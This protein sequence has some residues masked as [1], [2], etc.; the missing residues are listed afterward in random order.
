MSPEQ[1]LGQVEAGRRIVIADMEAGVGNLTRM[2]EGSVDAILAIVEATPKSIE[3]ARRAR[4]IA[5]ERRVGPVWIVANRVRDDTDRSLLASAFGLVAFEIP[6][7]DGILRAD[8]D[9]RSPLDADP[10]GP[11]VRAIVAMARDLIA[12]ARA[13]SASSC[14]T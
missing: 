10:E 12:A 4:D 2:S 8:R 7:D 9:G 1:L 14:R 11:A 3:V 6:E 5:A 13:S